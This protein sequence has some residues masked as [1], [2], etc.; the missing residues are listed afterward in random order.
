MNSAVKN[1]QSKSNWIEFS[2]IHAGRMPNHMDVVSHSR[3]VS[4][5]PLFGL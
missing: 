5:W 1:R 4:H 2:Q 3:L